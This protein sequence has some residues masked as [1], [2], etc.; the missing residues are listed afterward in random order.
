M[1][2]YSKHRKTATHL[3]YQLDAEGR[4]VPQVSALVVTQ[5]PNKLNAWLK[6]AKALDAKLAGSADKLAGF[7]ESNTTSDILSQGLQ[8]KLDAKAATTEGFESEDGIETRNAF[9]IFIATDLLQASLPAAFP[10]H[11]LSYCASCSSLCPGR[12]TIF[13]PTCKSA[14]PISAPS[15][16]PFHQPR[17]S[18][19]LVTTSKGISTSRRPWD[20]M[21]TIPGS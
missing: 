18:S 1:Y 20:P 2:N 19:F 9:E 21:V 4:W 8:H 10:L 6:V 13:L 3:G 12:Y 5:R 17:F 15:T 16:L 14:P 11:P 7:V